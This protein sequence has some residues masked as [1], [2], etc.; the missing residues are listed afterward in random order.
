MQGTSFLSSLFDYSFSTFITS[1]IIKVLYILTTIVVA[2]WTLALIL[3]GFRASTGFGIVMLLVG[4]PIFFLISMIY[5]RVVLELIM[6]IF[7]I[8]EDVDDINRRGGG[9]DRER[10]VEPTPAPVA[11]EPAVA[12]ASMATVVQES[13]PA[14]E[15]EAQFCAACG[16]ERAAGKSFCTACGAAYA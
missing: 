2:F 8:H 13:A 14:H 12:P 15:P 1:R 5:A 4:G 3:Y 7:R 9:G 11:P 16:A 6:V 10:A